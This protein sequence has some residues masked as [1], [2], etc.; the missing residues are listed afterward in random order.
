M[1][2]LIGGYGPKGVQ[3]IL[4]AD[5]ADGSL[6]VTPVTDEAENPSWLLP[7]PNGET[8]YAVEE[9]VPD[10]GLAVFRRAGEGWRLH[11][12]FEVGS[13]PCHLALDD[14]N[15]FLFVSNYMDGSLDVWRLDD[16]GLPIEKTDTVRHA[17]HGPNPERQEGPHIHSALYLD[18]L[19]YVADLGLDQVSVYRLARD[20]GR[21]EEA[22]RI[23][24]PAGCGPR[25]MAAHPSQPELL[26]VDAELQGLVFAVRRDTGEILQTLHAVPEDVTVPFRT[27]AIHFAGDTLYVATREADVLALMTLRQ[28]GTL[29]E[30]VFYHHRQ[31][32][33]R[34]VWMDDDW[35]ITADEGSCALTLLRREGD[36]LTEV[37]KVPTPGLGPTCVMPF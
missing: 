8:L 1:R 26:Y 5:L 24:F 4:R 27:S 18:G 11:G 12:R 6:T 21:L 29:T 23:Q 14:A 9:R 7:H 17:G 16:D 32:T 28:D 33:P 34:D 36:R 3:S 25:H 19:V 10:G 31:Q 35:C 37:Q 20:T 2:F 30:P 13:A 15:R 22:G